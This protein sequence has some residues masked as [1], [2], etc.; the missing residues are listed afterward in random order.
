VKVNPKLVLVLSLAIACAC[1]S[2]PSD[3]LIAFHQAQQCASVS[4]DAGT[5]AA[6]EVL[7]SARVARS[8]AFA[9]IYPY[10]ALAY[11]RTGNP[12]KAA[13]VLETLRNLITRK[14]PGYLNVPN[15][16]RPLA[17]VFAAM[18]ACAPLLVSPDARERAQ[19][20]LSLER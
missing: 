1:Q 2:A 3:G 5:I 6:F 16:P 13:S 18:H 14:S 17:D 4:D 11:E 10:A 20:V 9:S 7:S 15:N 12:S 8:G 19:D